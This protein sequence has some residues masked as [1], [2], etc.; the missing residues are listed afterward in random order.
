MSR[1]RHEFVIRHEGESG[2]VACMR[3]TIHAPTRT[4]NMDMGRDHVIFQETPLSHE[5]AKEIAQLIDWH[6]AKLAD[7]IG[8]SWL[9]NK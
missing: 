4:A 6:E 2:Q 9:E 1:V 7:T 3:S 5:A 8:K